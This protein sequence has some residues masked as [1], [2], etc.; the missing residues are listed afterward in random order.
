MNPDHHRRLRRSRGFPDVE[1]ETVFTH[2]RR[3]IRID[4]GGGGDELHARRAEVRGTSARCGSRHQS[5]ARAGGWLPAAIARWRLGITKAFESR[6]IAG[7]FAACETP[8][9]G[10]YDRVRRAGQ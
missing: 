2:A 9:R 1:E 6:D 8:L 3:K 5:T 10:F 4:A 7:Q